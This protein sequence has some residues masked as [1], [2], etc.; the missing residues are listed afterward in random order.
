[1]FAFEIQPKFK[2]CPLTISYHG[3]LGNDV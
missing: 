2:T 3:W 1:L